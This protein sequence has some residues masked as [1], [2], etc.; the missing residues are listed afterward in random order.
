MGKQ[1]RQYTGSVSI[2]K[3]VPTVLKDLPS[4]FEILQQGHQTLQ[5]EIQDAQLNLNSDKEEII[6]NISIS[7]ILQ[8]MCSYQKLLIVY[9]EFTFTEQTV[10]YLTCL[11]PKDYRI[12]SHFTL[13]SLFPQKAYG[14]FFRLDFSKLLQKSQIQPTACF[15]TA[16]KLKTFFK[17]FLMIEE[18]NRRTTYCGTFR[19][20]EI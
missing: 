15:Y 12:A 4:L 17:H 8:G 3:C 7:Q 10:L 14:F 11:F 16:H 6:F 13:A 20:Y 18:I 1:L 9:L 2:P 5:V 19:L